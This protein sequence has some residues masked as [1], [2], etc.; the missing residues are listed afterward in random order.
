MIKAGRTLVLAGAEADFA[1]LP[2]GN[3]IGG[4]VAC[5]LAGGKIMRAQGHLI[6]ADLSAIALKTEL[7]RF[8]AKQLPRLGAHYPANGFAVAILPGH[9][10]LLRAVATKMP[11]WPGLYNA[12]LVGWVSAVPLS[13]LGQME[14]KIFC[15]NATPRRDSAALMY[16]YLPDNM[17]PALGIVNLFAASSCSSLRFPAGG[18]TIKGNCLINGQKANLS[19]LIATGEIDPALPL[20]ADR[21][22]AL[23]NNSIIANDPKTGLI[24][25][26]NPIDP[27]LTYRF[28]EPFA[29][30]KSALT[31]AAAGLNLPGAALASVCIASLRHLDATTRPMLPAIAPVT[32]GQIGYTVLTQT[33][34]CLS[35][36]YL[37]GELQE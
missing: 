32:F 13:Q 17:F 8:P 35:L 3:W 12:P 30:F 6:Y 33:I 36:S 24:T 19:R 18:Y 37:A 14:P 34:A 1:G 11:D 28:A 25:F 2:A 27:T 4:T 26:L 16:V 31:M 29:D 23:L 20:T 7:R 15:G 22:G 9:S 21:S 5:F 10:P